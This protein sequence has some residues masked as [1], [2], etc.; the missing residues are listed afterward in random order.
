MGIVGLLVEA[1]RRLEEEFEPS[2]DKSLEKMMKAL[3]MHPLVSLER[4]IASVCGFLSIF[5]ANQ[6]L[7]WIEGALVGLH[8]LFPM[9]TA[10]KAGM[11]LKSIV[12]FVVPACIAASYCVPLRLEDHSKMFFLR[13]FRPLTYRRDNNYFVYNPNAPHHSSAMGYSQE[14]RRSPSNVE[15]RV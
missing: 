15:N 13:A 4:L 6:Y 5:W 14:V 12:Y 7:Y 1:L 3:G 11:L 9:V 2:T 10:Y 8:L